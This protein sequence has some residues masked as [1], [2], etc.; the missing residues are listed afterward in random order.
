MFT[1]KR[2]TFAAI[3]SIF[4]ATSLPHLTAADAPAAAPA[5]ASEGAV[6]VEF[7]AVFE[8]I[9][10]K[11]KVGQNTESDLATE[12]AAIDSILAKHAAEKTDEVAMIALMKARLYLEVFENTEKGIALL[13][14]LKLDFPQTEIAKN[15][16]QAVDA[17]EKQAAAT[18][19]L[20][21]GKQ[22]PPFSEKDLNDKPLALA[23]FKGK[24]VLVDFWAT[25][26]GPCVQELPN[27]L[28]A[29]EKFHS[30]GFEIVGISLDQSK[31][32]LIGFI[33][34]RGMTWAQ[35]FDGLGWKNKLGEQYGIQ[36]IPA[37]FL[38]DGEGK[39]IARNLRGPA[40]E[41]QLADLLK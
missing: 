35:Y 27:V 34:E 3:A 20:A 41:K 29:Y 19:R 18:S 40:L 28:A 2:L 16:D 5:P 12:I 22:F 10:A 25:W 15:I 38:L 14:Q 11:L 37:T 39:I 26:C 23:D 21:V 17:L 7:K 13:K 8:K 30:K 33:K 9:T 6:T 31:D 36:S 4:V 1:M 24:I 32:A